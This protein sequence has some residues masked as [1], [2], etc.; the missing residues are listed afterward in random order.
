MG[1]RQDFQGWW[2]DK[3]DGISR[4]VEGATAKVVLI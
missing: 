3:Q 2:E 4:H 1:I